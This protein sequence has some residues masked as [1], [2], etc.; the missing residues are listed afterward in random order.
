MLAKEQIEENNI[1]DLSKKER[2]SLAIDQ[3]I[4]EITKEEGFENLSVRKITRRANV[5]I[6][7][8][9][10]YYNSIEDLL[11]IHLKKDLI[12]KNQYLQEH[13]KDSL[14]DNLKLFIETRLWFM[15]RG[16]Q[17]IAYQSM[18]S[19]LKYEL[20]NRTAQQLATQSTLVMLEKAYAKGEIRP[21][22]SLS[23]IAQ[24]IHVILTGFAFCYNIYSYEE[25]LE[26]AFEVAY[27]YITNA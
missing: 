19:I 9:Y 5:S 11:F 25:A 24:Q 15:E 8:F 20:H 21:T 23:H 27:L 4:S 22:A 13:F 6:G 1:H 14:K 16:N 7:T 26:K 17:Q 12:N 3:A 10:N 18:I 2:T